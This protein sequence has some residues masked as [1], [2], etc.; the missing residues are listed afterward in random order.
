MK[1]GIKMSI[2]VLVPIAHGTEEMEAVIIV[3]MLRRA[4]YDVKVAGESSINTCAR[5]IKILPD[6]HIDDL[7][8]YDS[9]DAIVIPGGLT[10]VERLSDSSALEKITKAHFAAGKL[11]AAV[12]AAPTLLQDFKIV[13]SETSV[14]SH[15][16]VAGKLNQ[17]YYSTEKV[18]RDN[19]IITSRGAGTTFDFALAIIEFFSGKAAADKIANDIVYF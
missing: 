12:C 2:N 16:S 6:I 15:P 7:D 1:K 4:G 19:N 9:F 17:E 10:G 5:G 13:T 11:I 14:T 8:E 18:V 3:D